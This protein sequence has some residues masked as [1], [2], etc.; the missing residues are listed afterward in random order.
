MI[1]ENVISAEFYLIY[2]H[3]TGG[4]LR[5]ISTCGAKRKTEGLPSLAPTVA[6]FCFHKDMKVFKRWRTIT[7][8]ATMFIFVPLDIHFLSLLKV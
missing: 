1:A 2:Q 4:K 3:T 7:P 8:V 5:M 6:I